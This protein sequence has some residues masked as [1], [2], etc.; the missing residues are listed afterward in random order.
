MAKHDQCKKLSQSGYINTLQ[1][2]KKKHSFRPRT[3]T[4]K[5]KLYKEK[6]KIHIPITM[7]SSK[8]VS[9]SLVIFLLLIQQ[10]TVAEAQKNCGARWN[11]PGCAQKKVKL[12]L[13]R[14]KF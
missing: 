9:I 5:N 6:S 1:Q 13:F 4:K 3:E 7:D 14:I 11:P 10:C 12:N 8:M 2:K